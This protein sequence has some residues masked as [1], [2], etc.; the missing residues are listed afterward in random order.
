MRNRPLCGGCLIGSG[1]GELD[2]LW[3]LR[4]ILLLLPK[5]ALDV[6]PPGK[7][8]HIQHILAKEQEVVGN[9]DQREQVVGE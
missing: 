7:R 5:Q 6:D 3:R 8:D 9:G 2:H 1:R 4:R